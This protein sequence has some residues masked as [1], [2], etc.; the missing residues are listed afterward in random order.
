MVS[1]ARAGYRVRAD[2][3]KLVGRRA[4]LLRVGL[5]HTHLVPPHASGATFPDM[6][7]A[8]GEA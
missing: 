6:P 8:G 4:D 7:V 2:T 5:A 3:V 1:T